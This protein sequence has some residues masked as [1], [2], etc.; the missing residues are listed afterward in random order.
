MENE[1][2][3]KFDVKIGRVD[4]FSLGTEDHGLLTFSVCLDFKG[5]SQCLAGYAIDTYDEET[6]ERRGTV[7]G[8]EC[9]LRLLR[10][11]QVDDID[12]IE[13]KPICALY[14]KNSSWNSKILGLAPLP[15]DDGKVFLIDETLAYS[16]KF[17]KIKEDE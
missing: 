3:E 1:L 8:T 5:T 7:F 17:D 14:E 6:K 2:E 11:F 15:C 10:C 16:K 9:I 12:K 4:S 13:G